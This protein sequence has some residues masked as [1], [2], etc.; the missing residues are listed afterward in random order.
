MTDRE[1]WTF[2]TAGVT[3]LAGL[4]WVNNGCFRLIIERIFSGVALPS[5]RSSQP[6]PPSTPS[7]PPP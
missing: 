1:I 3:I 7:P 5:A 6:P 2:I 4:L